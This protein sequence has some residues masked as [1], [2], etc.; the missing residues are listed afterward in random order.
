MAKP[1]VAVVGRPNVGKSTLF[2]RL[3]GERRAIVQDEPGTTRDRVYGD[4]E[5]NGV[6]FALIDTG[7]IIVDE[8]GAE[9]DLSTIPTETRKQAEHAIEEADVIVM[10]VDAN[11]GTTSA[12]HAVADLVRRT[13]K[14][15][16]LAANKAESNTRAANAVDFYELGLTDPIVV[17]SLHGRGTGDLLDAIVA[18]LPDRD[19]EAEATGPRIA[20]VGRPNVGKSRLL[21]AF[22]GQERAI[23]SDEPGTTRDS[24]D[25]VLEW[26]GQ[27]ITLVDTAGIRRRGKIEPGI[28]KYS[29]LRSMRAITRADVVLLVV[30]AT[31]GFT[32]QDLHIAGYVADEARG[33]VL[34]VNKW[35]LVEKDGR[36][37]EQYREAA[38]EA[39][40]F[41]PYV[42]AVFISAKFNQRVPQAMERALLVM[43]ERQKRVPTAALNKMLR[44]AVE[45]HAPPSKPGKWVKFYYATQ[46][47]VSPPSFVFF[48]NHAEDVHFS[49]RRYL[50][51]QL[52][53][54][55][56]F[57]GNPIRM[58]FRNRQEPAP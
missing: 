44:T 14:P 3:I 48:C 13:R 6:S 46:V 26:E 54:E 32:S 18:A 52:R 19:E 33:M 8:R 51:N 53:E 56:G 2:N 31:E 27:T 49:Y 47:D 45:K 50:E 41:M 7:G 16:V 23:V 42:P 29:V 58:R 25:T 15:V 30:D 1:I 4:V 12:D 17:S 28:E 39:L 9:L 22:L 21:N 57:I 55:F 36:T 38:A 35:D 24:L 37:M 11:I 43:E 34:V 10:V 5:W 40:D 20:I